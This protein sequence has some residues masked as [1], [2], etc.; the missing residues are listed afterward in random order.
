M[1]LEVREL[2]LESL[3]MKEQITTHPK[4]CEGTTGQG[5]QNFNH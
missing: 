2:E 3:H 1:D 5:K 4:N